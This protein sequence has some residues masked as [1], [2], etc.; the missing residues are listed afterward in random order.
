MCRLGGNALLA[1]LW[2]GVLH[3]PKL[4]VNEILKQLLE[5]K[6]LAALPCRSLLLQVRLLLPTQWQLR[7]Q[8]RAWY[9]MLSAS[10]HKTVAKIS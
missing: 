6:R 10:L 8:P 2:L 5:L 3:K 4:E 1:C 9:Q 7:R